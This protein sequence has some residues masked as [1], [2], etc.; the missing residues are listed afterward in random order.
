MY[1]FKIYC[2]IIWFTNYISL[3]Q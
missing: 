2:F 1:G 3:R